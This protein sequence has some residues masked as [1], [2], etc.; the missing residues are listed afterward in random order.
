M[1]RLE[2]GARPKILT[3]KQAAWTTE[4]LETKAAGLPMTDTVRF[5][6]RHVD[7][8]LALREEA[9]GKCIYCESKVAVGETDHI[10]PVVERP[11]KICEWENL[12][13]CCKECNQ[14]K[15]SYFS[16][17]EPLVNPFVDDPSKYLLFLALLFCIGAEKPW[18]YAREP[19]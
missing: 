15:A 10:E 4:Y 7:I 9:H 2:K 11:E 13:L 18:D 1:I 6:Y 16:P 3:E 5:R 17:T 14:A 12:A 8:K 19:S